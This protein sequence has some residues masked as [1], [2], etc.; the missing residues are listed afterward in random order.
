MARSISLDVIRTAG[1]EV[2]YTLRAALAPVTVRR[3]PKPRPVQGR[4]A[5]VMVHG[6]M[7]HPGMLRPLSR[8]LLTEG[9]EGVHRVGYPSTMLPLERIVDRI[10]G[11]VKPLA[12]DGPVDLIGHSMGAV[13]CRAFLKEFGGAPYVRRFVS[14]GGPHAGTTWYRLVPPW[15][16]PALNPRGKWVERLSTGPEPVPTTVIRASYDHQVMPPRRASIQGV[17]ELIIHDHGHNGLLWSKQAHDA[18]VSALTDPLIL[19]GS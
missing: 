7:G 12:K 16:Q 17:R 9:F 1:N 14:L 4:P 3:L 18:V 10:A 8:R 2:W 19:G 15:V 5:V 6:F 11:V 13:A